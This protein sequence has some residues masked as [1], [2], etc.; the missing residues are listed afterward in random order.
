MAEG[1]LNALYGDRYQGYSAGTEPTKVNP[2]VIKA[3]SEIGIDISEFRS[4][5][6]KEFYGRSF[7]LVITL[8]DD[9]REVCPFFLGHRIIHKSFE[10]P[11]EIRGTEDETMRKVRR[12]RGEIRNWIE[13]VFATNSQQL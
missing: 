12:I 9:A 2:H 3:M 1:I 7:D 8:C 11:A 13:A 10:D 4:K 6:I 5:S